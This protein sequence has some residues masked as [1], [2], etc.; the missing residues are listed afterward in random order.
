MKYLKIYENFDENDPFGEEIRHKNDNIIR[1]GD[2]V[3][4]I[5]S[6]GIIQDY[7][8]NYPRPNRVYTVKL[9][10]G[11]YLKLVEVRGFWSKNRFEKL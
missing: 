4:L 5:Y 9:I 3:I 2:R 10:H 7:D 8:L 6:F 1:E 11:E